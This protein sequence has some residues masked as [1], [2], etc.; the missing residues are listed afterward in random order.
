M[1]GSKTQLGGVEILQCISMCW[2][3]KK[4]GMYH[5]HLKTAQ[6]WD[7]PFGSQPWLWGEIFLKPIETSSIVT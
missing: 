4:K 5:Y 2:R 6:M 1:M 3:G 7:I